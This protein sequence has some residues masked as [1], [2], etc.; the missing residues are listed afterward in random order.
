MLE[1]VVHTGITY[2]AAHANIFIAYNLQFG[3]GAQI[4]SWPIP[5]VI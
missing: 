2:L 3:L 5:V 1:P 4:G